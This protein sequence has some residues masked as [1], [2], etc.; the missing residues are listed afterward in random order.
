[1][2]I[3][4][5]VAYACTGGLN[6]TTYVTPNSG[7]RGSSLTVQ[8]YTGGGLL[9]KSYPGFYFRYA[10]PGDSTA[11]HHETTIG[12]AVTSTA[13]GDIGSSANKYTRTIPNL[14]STGGTGQ[15]CWATGTMNPD[16]IAQN[17]AIT[18]N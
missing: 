16:E 15:A 8:T 13:S 7:T 3:L 5:A 4:G 18:V 14:G 6:E 11:C 10:Y 9:K 12:A 1:L 17:A 2:S